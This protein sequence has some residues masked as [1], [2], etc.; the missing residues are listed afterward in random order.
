MRKSLA[1]NAILDTSLIFM[2]KLHY[3]LTFNIIELSHD[4]KK[5]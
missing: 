3:S 1:C 2:Q 5:I 4:K